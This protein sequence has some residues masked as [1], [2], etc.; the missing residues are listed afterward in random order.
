MFKN[1]HTLFSWIRYALLGLGKLL[2]NF[3]E[4]RPSYKGGLCLNVTGGAFESLLHG[5]GPA[6]M[7]VFVP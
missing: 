4:Q 7:F 5:G 2:S 3:R 6:F 1:E